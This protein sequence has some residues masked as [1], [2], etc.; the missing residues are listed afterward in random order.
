MRST[1]WRGWSGWPCRSR[2]WPSDPWSGPGAGCSRTAYLDIVV[3]SRAGPPTTRPPRPSSIAS[4]SATTLRCGR[5]RPPVWVSWWSRKNRLTSTRASAPTLGRRSIRVVDGGQSQRRG[6]DGS[7]LGVEVS[8]EHVTTVQRG[9][10]VQGALGIGGLLELFRLIRPP[11]HG[12][13]TAG[14]A[15]GGQMG[16]QLAL[17]LGEGIDRGVV[18][19][20]HDH[21]D[22]ALGQRPVAIGGGAHRQLAQP[23][24]HR[25]QVMGRTRR[26][27]SHIPQPRRH[28][29]CRVD[30]PQLRRIE[31]TDG[32]C[33]Q[34]VESV[35]Q[36]QD[37]RQ[38]H[39]VER[40]PQLL[41]RL[42]QTFQHTAIVHL[43]DQ[44]CKSIWSNARK[45][46]E[47]IQVAAFTAD[48]ITR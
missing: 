10:Q 37:L 19:L 34:R 25:H 15:Q 9:R 45:I 30:I 24:G 36:G 5:S 17:D 38:R 1:G 13:G 7:A 33:D 44:L 2:G 42:R 14:Q 40:Y 11:G 32:L 35:P 22:L 12:P 20:G 27:R 23:T 41:D 16:H 3:P 48:R 39:T 4:T 46:F 8:L 26:H 47:S 18:E 29:R 31:L 21:L 28:R 6:H 43:F